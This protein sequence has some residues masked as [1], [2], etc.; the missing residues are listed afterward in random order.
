MSASN[1]AA[2][3]QC[4]PL[5][6]PTVSYSLSADHF[7]SF[8]NLVIVGLGFAHVYYAEGIFLHT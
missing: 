2:D 4:L 5:R 6:F 7:I 3:S 1:A 8:C